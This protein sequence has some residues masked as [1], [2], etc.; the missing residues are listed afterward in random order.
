MPP[1]T[2]HIE[3]SCHI[4]IT[5]THYELLSLFAEVSTLLNSKFSA[6]FFHGGDKMSVF[7]IFS[8]SL[9]DE[10]FKKLDKYCKILYI[11]S[12]Q[13]YG[14]LILKQS[15]YRYTEHIRHQFPSPFQDVAKL[16][17]TP[18]HTIMT[19]I[20]GIFPMINCCYYHYYQHYHYYYYYYYY[21]RQ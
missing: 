12:N 6:F 8:Y 20:D 17:F 14:H 5:Q 3:E 18:K 11:E 4:T 2:R 7:F 13:Y 21:Y 19:K 9:Q 15:Q 1:Q 10:L 16:L